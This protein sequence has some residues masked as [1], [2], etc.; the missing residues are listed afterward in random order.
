MFAERDRSLKWQRYEIKYL[1]GEAQAAEIR[2]YCRKYLPPD[3]H[4]SH[5]VDCEYPVLSVYLDSPSRELLRA[6]LL[7]QAQRYKLRVR[8][9]RQCGE[10]ATNLPAYYEI[11][12]KVCGV[13]HK[14]RAR[15]EPPLAEHLLWQEQLVPWGGNGKAA[16]A[17][18]N[19]NEFQQLQGRI[20][21][22]PAVGVFYRR[23]AYEG[24]S[25][26]NVRVTLDRDLHYGLLAP[27][28][29][30]R[31]EMWW[32]VDAGG[33][34][35][36]IKFTDTYPFWVADMLHRVELMQRGVCKYVICSCAAGGCESGME[37]EQALP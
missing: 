19:L 20:G 34:I 14:T 16:A 24:T 4:S 37:V 25:A 11:K 13:V 33:V 12:R 32:P 27:P 22:R 3:P 26:D 35:L 10:S 1:I 2:H 23:E 15:V 8:T 6:T 17:E 7:R 21:A 18:A 36:E 5:R 9:Y 29:N 30:G 31:R 28:G